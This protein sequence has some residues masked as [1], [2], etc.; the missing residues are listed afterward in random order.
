M[1]TNQHKEGGALPEKEEKGVNPNADNALPAEDRP[2]APSDPFDISLP[3][4]SIEPNP[5]HYTN[6]DED[7][8]PGDFDHNHDEV[9]PEDIYVPGLDDDYGGLGLAYGYSNNNGNGGGAYGVGGV[10]DDDDGEGGITDLESPTKSLSSLA[11]SDSDSDSDDDGE[12]PQD[13]EEGEEAEGP[14]RAGAG[15]LGGGEGVEE[16]VFEPDV[17]S[18]QKEEQMR[19]L[20]PSSSSGNN[21][22]NPFLDSSLRLGMTEPLALLQQYQSQSQISQSQERSLGRG[23]SPNKPL[24]SLQ[25]SQP[26][27]SP[28]SPDK[29][30]SQ[31]QR[32]TRR[33]SSTISPAK[34]SQAMYGKY[35]SQFDVKKRVEEVDKLLERDLELDSSYAGS[36]VG[37]SVADV[38]E[39]E[40]KEGEGDEKLFEGWL[41]DTSD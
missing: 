2:N 10:Y 29:L 18:T 13:P 1:N 23:R 21:N 8:H 33:K 36:V 3:P 30:T 28:Q 17:V 22:N 31:S 41:K 24:M 11:G 19:L 26:Q 37:A 15:A 12:L 6:D 16:F 35:N 5:D 40:D 4:T 7:H 9:D 32:L 27:P 25:S 20:V 34:S 39:D 38:D 14:G